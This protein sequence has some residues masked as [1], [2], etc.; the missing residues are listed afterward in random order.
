VDLTT[1]VINP[2]NAME[3]DFWTT[4]LGQ[5]TLQ[6]VGDLGLIEYVE[7]FLFPDVLIDFREMNVLLRMNRL[8]AARL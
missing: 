2:V 3:L 7:Y 6:N 1:E 4:V 8:H 5:N